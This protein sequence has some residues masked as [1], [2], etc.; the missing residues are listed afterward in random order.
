[1]K[2]TFEML[3]DRPSGD[4]VRAEV[5]KT[6]QKVRSAGCR[7][8]SSRVKENMEEFSNLLALKV[9]EAIAPIKLEVEF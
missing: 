7:I 6:I 3:K 2:E 4:N 1:M 8:C 5:E 9:E